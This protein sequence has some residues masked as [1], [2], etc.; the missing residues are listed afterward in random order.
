MK[1]IKHKNKIPIKLI[2]LILI[3]AAFTSN[4]AQSRNEFSNKQRL[5][6]S[7]LNAR[8]F[9]KAKSIFEYLDKIQPLNYNVITSLNKI[10]VQLREYDKS[11]GLLQSKITLSSQNINY[12]GLLGTTY[13]TKEDRDSASIVWHKATHL[14]NNAEMNFRIIANYIIQI[15]DYDA[16]IEILREGKNYS[17]NPN[18]FSYELANLFSVLMKYSDAAEEYCEIIQ[19]DPRQI[20]SV[21]NRMSAYISRKPALDETLNS[22]Q[23]FS[24]ENNSDI[25]KELLGYLY[26]VKG[27]SEKAFEIIQTLDNKH[28]EKG[29][30]IFK[31]SEDAFRQ[32]DFKIAN[33]GYDYLIK[34]YANQPF[35]YAAQMGF[36]R[37]Q[38]QLLNDKYLNNNEWKTISTPDTS[39][40][41]EFGRLSEN[42]QKLTDE[43][44]I[45]NYFKTEALYDAGII[46]KEKLLNYDSATEYFNRVISLFPNSNYG[47][48]AANQLGEISIIQNNLGDAEKYFQ[49]VN[50]KSKNSGAIKNAVLYKLAEINFWR[51]KN[52]KALSLLSQVSSSLKDN[53]AND[54]IA[55]SIL[56]TTLK[57]DSL[58]GILFAAGERL[59]KQFHFEKAIKLFQKIESSSQ[60]III[61]QMSKFK[62]AELYLA[63]SDYM[64]A[65]PIF[66]QLSK[67]EISKLY[68]DQSL[69]LLGKVYLN[70]LKNDDKAKTIFEKLLAKYPNSVYFSQ[71]RKIINAIIR[72][73]NN[74]L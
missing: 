23:N 16:A 42:F 39:G 17:K 56:I 26:S 33:F 55:L 21:K 50:Q 12:Y 3:F 61:K 68:S 34:N 35:F 44:N 60:Q 25:V 29:N 52:T 18:I 59:I 19:R 70:G 36:A 65:I 45:P 47:I 62:L 37:T 7:Y 14:N 10:Y 67:S 9:D 72:K 40:A 5:A 11:I 54:A 8:Q 32:N 22:V 38:F 57:S 4:F 30:R 46:Y 24:D 1:N 64:K 49:I 6:Q 27:D 66:E 53:S 71:S 28:N 69:F 41:F 43:K 58:N 20:A 48:L 73:G 15:R 13:Y 74:I 51:G 31:F 63:T 2:F